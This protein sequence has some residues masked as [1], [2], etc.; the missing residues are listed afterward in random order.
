MQVSNE[1]ALAFYKHHGFRIVETV[2]SYYL[3]IEPPD[4]YLLERKVHIVNESKATTLHR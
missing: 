2:K 4:A 1:D 3:R